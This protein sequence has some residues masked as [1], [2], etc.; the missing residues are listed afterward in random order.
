MNNKQALFLILT[1]IILC[2]LCFY[3]GVYEGKNNCPAY[4]QADKVS[5][6]YF[7]KYTNTC[8][9]FIN[10]CN[11]RQSKD[12]IMELYRRQDLYYEVYAATRDIGDSQ[13]K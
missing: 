6:E 10:A 1:I 11:S 7:N 4:A 8:Q 3:Q 2:V 12:S 5:N 9:Q 13:Y